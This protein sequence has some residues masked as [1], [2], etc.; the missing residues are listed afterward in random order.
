MYTYYFFFRENDEKNGE[1]ELLYVF[2]YFLKLLLL[3]F[4]LQQKIREIQFHENF[5]FWHL[6]LFTPF[7]IIIIFLLV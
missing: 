7:I 6:L 3:L 5:G 2:L 4:P 1:I